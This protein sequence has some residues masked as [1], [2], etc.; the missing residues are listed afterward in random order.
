MSLLSPLE[1]CPAPMCWKVQDT[2][3][4][5][6]RTA[7]L[8]AVYALSRTAFPVV[9]LHT[10][11]FITCCCSR[12]NVIS[13]H[14]FWVNPEGHVTT[15][16]G[17]SGRALAKHLLQHK[18]TKRK[19]DGAAQR[20]HKRVTAAELQRSYSISNVLLEACENYSPTH[21]GGSVLCLW[22][23]SPNKFNPLTQ[24]LHALETSV[25]L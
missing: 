22:V 12:K 21:W 17:V 4:S 11:T 25:T 9:C 6:W 10:F 8:R 23:P 16:L 19:L 2:E 24:V 1:R 18:F 7:V 13:A 15:S 20:R 5:F 3:E 14:L